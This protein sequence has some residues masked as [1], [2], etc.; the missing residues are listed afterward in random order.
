MPVSVRQI[1]QS[2]DG[3]H[4]CSQPIPEHMALAVGFVVETPCNMHSSTLAL[5]GHD[6]HS[7]PAKFYMQA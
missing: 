2:P 3:L 4:I 1:G 5:T 7:K 6:Q